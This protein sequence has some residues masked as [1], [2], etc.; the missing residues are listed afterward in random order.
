MQ[1]KKKLL[2]SVSI[3]KP[4]HEQI[5]AEMQKILDEQLEISLLA[6]ALPPFNPPRRPR[7]T[8]VRRKIDKK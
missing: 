5:K 4:S 2:S 1:T 8:A 3:K 7:A 6:F